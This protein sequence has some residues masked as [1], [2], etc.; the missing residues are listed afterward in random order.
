MRH[1]SH[2]I[3]YWEDWKQLLYPSSI[4]KN[5]LLKKINTNVPWTEHTL[6]HT[7]ANKFEFIILCF[8]C[9]YNPLM[10]IIIIIIIFIIM[11]R[12]W[13]WCSFTLF[14]GHWSR[15]HSRNKIKTYSFFFIFL[16]LIILSLHSLCVCFFITN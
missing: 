7:P 2:N 9:L 4:L 12:R 5:Y 1:I 6:T 11:R 15:E 3:V 10:M 13:C 8:S 14:Y 16:I